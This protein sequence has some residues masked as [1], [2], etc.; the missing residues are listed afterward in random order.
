MAK[1]K[2]AV[3]PGDIDEF[4]DPTTDPEL[5]KAM[6]EFR[7]LVADIEQAVADNRF[8]ET[9]RV[10]T[11]RGYILDFNSDGV[12]CATFCVDVGGRVRTTSSSAFA[13]L[14]PSTQVI[15]ASYI[16][17]SRYD[18][19]SFTVAHGKALVGNTANESTDTHDSKEAA[20]AVCRLLEQHG[21]G[22]EGK[23]FPVSTRVERIK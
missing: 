8:L 16:L 18:S 17:N 1:K 6:L 3:E 11:Q 14:S 5:L 12:L 10:D 20:E 15:L 2:T 19:P 13:S 22:G 7:V 23:I 21:F 4:P 9:V